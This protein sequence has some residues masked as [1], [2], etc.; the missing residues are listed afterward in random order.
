M[1]I[2]FSFYLLKKLTFALQECFH[3]ARIRTVL[4]CDV[5]LLTYL[6]NQSQSRSPLEVLL[7]GLWI[8]L[9][10]IYFVFILI[11]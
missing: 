4:L 5:F 7:A 8:L 11:T 2:W 3:E 1:K 10:I 9:C 6:K